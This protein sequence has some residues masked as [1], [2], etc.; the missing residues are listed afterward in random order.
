M[1]VTFHLVTIPI[2]VDVVPW[3]PWP[4]YK[5]AHSIIYIHIHYRNACNQVRHSKWRT[6]RIYLGNIIRGNRSEGSKIWQSCRYG[7]AGY[8][9]PGTGKETGQDLSRLCGCERDWDPPIDGHSNYHVSHCTGDGEGHVAAHLVHILVN[10]TPPRKSIFPGDPQSPSNTHH[11]NA[12]G[13][14]PGTMHQLFFYFRSYHQPHFI[15]F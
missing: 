3:R 8:V 5:C 6:G 2:V 9:C 15:A 1:L 4:I 12:T 13:M 7:Q 14:S 10:T 11:Q